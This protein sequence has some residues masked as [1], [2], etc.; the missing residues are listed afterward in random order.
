MQPIVSASVHRARDLSPVEPTD[1][2]LYAAVGVCDTNNDKCAPKQWH[3]FQW[4]R[5]PAQPKS[6][7]E[8]KQSAALREGSQEKPREAERSER[9]QRIKRLGETKQTFCVSSSSGR[10]QKQRS[11]KKT[12]SKVIISVSKCIVYLCVCIIY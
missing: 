9:G 7:L 11:S 1:H 8:R 12:K 10:Q 5:M 3:Y 2:L 6:T 4:R